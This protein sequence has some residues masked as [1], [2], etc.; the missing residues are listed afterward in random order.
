[1]ISDIGVF[2]EANMRL[3]A[4]LSHF[5]IDPFHSFRMEQGPPASTELRTK[6]E[7]NGMSIG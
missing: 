2:I 7:V 3:S 6:S 5:R 1:M 4:Q